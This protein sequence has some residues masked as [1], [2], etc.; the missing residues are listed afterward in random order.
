MSK[1]NPEKA[2]AA[3]VPAPINVG[4]MSVRPFTLGMYAILERIKSPMLVPG[5]HNDILTTIPTLY[6]V[7]HDPADVLDNLA[8]IDRVALAW[9][10]TLH[11]S[12]MP[13]L[14]DACTAQFKAMLDVITEPDEKKR[15]AQRM[16]NHLCTVGRTDVRLDVGLHPV[17]VSR[18]GGVSDVPAARRGAGQPAIFPVA[19]R[20]D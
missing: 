4:D 8:D 13:K 19:N 12:V 5:E 10:D 3:L 17:A 11:P 16:D 20:G 15:S 7:T 6:A 9:A 2:M 1:S 18:L 14:K